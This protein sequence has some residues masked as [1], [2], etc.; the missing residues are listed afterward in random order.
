MSYH[1][2]PK[3]LLFDDLSASEAVELEI[4]CRKIVLE[5]KTDML[6][7]SFIAWCK[8]G[9]YD[10]RQALLVHAVAFPQRGLLS[11]VKMHKKE[12]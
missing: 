9:E 5:G 2:D 10:D 7:S 6:H 8:A 1:V 11:L 12:K 3:T 4:V